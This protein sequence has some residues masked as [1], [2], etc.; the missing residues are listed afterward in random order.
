V[1][2]ADG[3]D[4]AEGE[5]VEPDPPPHAARKT[6]TRTEVQPLIGRSIRVG[7]TPIKAPAAAITGDY[8]DT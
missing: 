5:L 2:G 8:L 3:V 6:A 1:T 7:R 4:D